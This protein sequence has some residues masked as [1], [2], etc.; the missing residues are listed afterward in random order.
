MPMPRLDSP[1]WRIAGATGEEPAVVEAALQ[2]LTDLGYTPDDI[3]TLCGRAI[4]SGMP[5]GE[6]AARLGP[7][8]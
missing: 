8:A 6:L 4:D 3:W 1:I 2:R 5:V 7:K